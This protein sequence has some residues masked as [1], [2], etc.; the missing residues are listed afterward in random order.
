[1]QN[2]AELFNSTNELD[3]LIT[4]SFTLLLDRVVNSGRHVWR[5]KGIYLMDLLYAAAYVSV[6]SRSVT[7]DGDG[8]AGWCSGDLGRFTCQAAV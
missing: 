6:D 1:M 2:L 7:S 4:R 3:A 8:N 5:H